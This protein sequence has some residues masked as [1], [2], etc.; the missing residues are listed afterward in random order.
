MPA[1]SAVYAKAIFES[2]TER[3][4]LDQAVV[5]LQSF[6]ETMESHIGLRSSLLHSGIE[7]RIKGILV[8]EIAKALQLQPSTTRI[9][10]LLAAKNRLENLQAIL[11]DL[12]E[13]KER[14]HGIRAG[15]LKSAVE[16]SS[17]DQQKVAAAISKKLGVDVRLKSVIDRSLLG[18]FIAEVG[19]KT[20]DASL[21]SQL[22]NFRNQSI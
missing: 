12:I 7:P 10:S 14:A 19:G 4:N 18:G 9:L 20:F 3:G 22:E 2:A 1:V 5:D 17:D 21:K 8:E 13:L 11:S 16:I 15:V 6:F